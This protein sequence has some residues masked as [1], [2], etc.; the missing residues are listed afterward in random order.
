MS[1]VS[2]I[3]LFVALLASLQVDAFVPRS[4]NLPALVVKS[5]PHTGLAPNT[6]RLK[7]NSNENEDK[8]VAAG[9]E[10]DLDETTKKYGL[11]AGLFKAITNKGSEQRSNRKIC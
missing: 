5:R 11:E 8:S 6:I 9:G 3:V 4:I 10:D 7:A 2:S 1:L